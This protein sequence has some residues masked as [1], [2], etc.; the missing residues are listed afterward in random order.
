MTPAEFATHVRYKTRTNSTTLTDA[1]ILALMKIRQTE[2]AEAIL[3]ADE[4]ILLLPQYRNLVADQRS[5]KLPEDI[6]SRLK[7]VE[8]K[9]DGTNWIPLVEIDI[10]KINTPIATE[11]NI[12][13][14]F[15]NSQVD[16]ENPNGAQFDILRKSLKLYTGTII[17][18]TNGLRCYCDTYPAPI[19]DLTS[20]TDMSIDPSTTTHGV[21]KSMHGIWAKGVII[22]YKESRE[23]PIP[24]TESEQLYEI[25]LQKAIEVLKHG[26]LDR[27]VHG[28][29]P[30]AQYR[31]NEGFDY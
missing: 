16:K 17:N 18:V 30:P 28:Y 9:L 19:T 25:N 5:Y 20:T 23:K 2:I 3:K 21:P 31:G 26:N 6:L 15:N 22:D 8:A 4:D 29:L 27:E 13:N 24:L 7:R 1:D 10:T 12:T 11:A 14:N